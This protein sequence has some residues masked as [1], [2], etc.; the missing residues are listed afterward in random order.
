MRAYVCVGGD[1]RPVP[2]IAAKRDDRPPPQFAGG[3][4]SRPPRGAALGAMY[5]SDRAAASA[6]AAVEAAVKKIDYTG[7]IVDYSDI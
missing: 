5:F 2:D 6:T 4:R 3:Y 1:R 7:K